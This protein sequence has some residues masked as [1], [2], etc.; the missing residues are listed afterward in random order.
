MICYFSYRERAAAWATVANPAAN[1]KVAASTFAV[2]L[3][4]LSASAAG[5]SGGGSLRGGREFGDS[6]SATAFDGELDW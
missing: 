1:E 5:G 6:K 4:P 3:T 2:M